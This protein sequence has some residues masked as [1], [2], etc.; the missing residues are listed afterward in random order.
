MDWVTVKL[1]GR[2]AIG[3]WTV[4]IAALVAAGLPGAASAETLRDALVQAYG[5]NPTLT[6]E[7]ARLRA[8]D[9][10][11]QIERAA[12]LPRLDVDSEYDEFIKR[13]ANSFTCASLLRTSARSARIPRA[14]RS[15]CATSCARTPTS[16]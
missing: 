12:G 7:R 3:R 5:G 11:V 8:T 14:S 10:D 4:S 2:A 1:R 9:E 16:C 15:R 6:G 13:S